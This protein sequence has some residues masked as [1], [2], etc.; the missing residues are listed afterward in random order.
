M[1]AAVSPMVTRL[2]TNRP[3]APANTGQ[4]KVARPKPTTAIGG[5][6]AVAMATP[7]IVPSRPRITA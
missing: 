2:V 6:S 4:L 3:S 7:T 1:T 5:I